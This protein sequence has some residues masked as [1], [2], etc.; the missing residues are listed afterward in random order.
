VAANCT[1]TSA[2]PQQVNV[3]SG[4]TVTAAFTVS[5]STPQVRA[6]VSGGGRIDPSIGKTTFGFN[7]DGRSGPPFQ[8]EMEVVYH[9]GTSPMTRIHSVVI[10][11]LTSSQDSRGGVCITWTGSARVNNGDQ[12]R[13]TATACD[14]GQPGSSPGAGPDRFGIIVDGSVS[15]GLTDLRGGN[16]QARQ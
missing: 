16:T 5:C 3:P 10:D 9:G 12:R 14:N 2:N 8:G 13:F 1:V 15:T 6:Q 4:G 11:G 7:V